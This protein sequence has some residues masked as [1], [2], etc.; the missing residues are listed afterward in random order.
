MSKKPIR[1]SKDKSYKRPKVT[2]QE[3][4]TSEEIS[5]KLEGY[6]K[7]ENVSDLSEMP[8]NTHMRYFTKQKNG[9]F[10]FRQ[11]GFLH[12]KN[13][14]EKYVVLSNGKNT[15]TVQTVDAV[16]YKK[17]NHSEELK[18]LHDKINKYEN[19]INLMNKVLINKLNVKYSLNKDSFVKVKK[20]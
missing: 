20:N 11:G 8:L 2:Q 12:N 13:N 9:E 5:Q 4:L 1:L 7:V 16:F 10:I 18:L 14:Y 6:V 15:W 17:L 19:A 3:Q